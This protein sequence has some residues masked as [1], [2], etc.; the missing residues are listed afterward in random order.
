VLFVANFVCERAVLCLAWSRVTVIGDLLI[1]GTSDGTGDVIEGCANG[2]AAGILI[3]VSMVEMLAEEF[4]HELV[5]HNYALK[6]Q[7]ILGLMF[8]L[9]TMAVLAIWA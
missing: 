6:F 4:T 3:Y 5:E 9:T 8:G 1:Q 2:L 7:M